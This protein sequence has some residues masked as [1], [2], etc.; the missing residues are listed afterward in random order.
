M[1]NRLRAGIFAACYVVFCVGPASA[2][3]D[4][5]GPPSSVSEERVVSAEST[6]YAL[7]LAGTYVLAPF[8]G[9]GLGGLMFQLTRNDNVSIWSGTVLLFA[10][11]VVHG[12]NGR[13]DHAVRAAVGLPIATTLGLILGGLIGASQARSVEDG[14][15]ETFVAGCAIGALVGYT[16][17]AIYDV[18]ANSSRHSRRKPADGASNEPRPLQFWAAPILRAGETRGAPTRAGSPDGLMLNL[19]LRVL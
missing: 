12:L 3:S 7:V 15:L 5:H 4:E 13:A 14:G 8:A 10:P 1:C 17:F 6:S 19:A 16:S 2:D 18:V 11:A 9:F